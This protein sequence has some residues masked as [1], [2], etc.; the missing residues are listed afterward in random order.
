MNREY[1]G[2]KYK[3]TNSPMLNGWWSITQKTYRSG[4]NHYEQNKQSVRVVALH[5]VILGYKSHVL[6]LGLSWLVGWLGGQIKFSYIYSCELWLKQ[7]LVKETSGTSDF[8]GGDLKK[9]THPFPKKK[10][11]SEM[12]HR[13]VLHFSCFVLQMQQDTNSFQYFEIPFSIL[14]LEVTMSDI[15]SMLSSS[16][17][18]QDLHGGT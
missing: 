17:S 6:E 4:R 5:L 8:I 14:S 7:A 16:Q 13:L 12:D 2:E 10:G 3:W 11:D 18:R 9:T 15:R 1:P